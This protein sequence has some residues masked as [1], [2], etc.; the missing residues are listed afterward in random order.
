VAD[1]PIKYI[2][3][4]HY[5]VFEEKDYEAWSAAGTNR[6]ASRDLNCIQQLR[7]HLGGLKELLTTPGHEGNLILFYLPGFRWTLDKLAERDESPESAD[8]L[9]M[10]AEVATVI[11]S[12]LREAGLTNHVRFMTAQD[13][14]PILEKAHASLKDNFTRFFIGD[15]HGIRYDGPKIVEAI[16]RLR[17]LGNGIP[18][19]RLDH[20]VLFRF[21]FRKKEKVIGDLGLFK[22]VSCATLAYRLR[23]E[24]PT[25]STFLFSVS[26]NVREITEP[27]DGLGKFERWSRA[28][29][30]RVYP[31]LIATPSAVDS[32]IDLDQCVD[33]GLLKR[34]YGID[35]SAVTG[36]SV[37]VKGLAEVGAHPFYA[38]VSGA[39]LCLSDGAIVDLPPFS[40]FRVNVMWID[41][42]LK[43]SLH[44]ALK[45][46]TSGETLDL[47]I[48]RLSN[49]RLD[50]VTVIKARPLVKRLPVY[51]F[52]S[53]LPTLLWGTIMDSWITP[54]SDSILKLRHSKLDLSKMKE[55]E[56]A[57]ERDGGGVLPKAVAK[58][59]GA[60]VFTHADS[61]TL[62]RSL[63]DC[64][65]RRV[66]KVRQMWA[67]LRDGD[68]RTFASYWAGDKNDVVST[69]SAHFTETKSHLWEGIAPNRPLDLPIK[70]IDD[71]SSSVASNILGLVNNA[72]TYVH[73]TTKWPQ[74]VQIFRS[75]PQGQFKGDLTWKPAITARPASMA[76]PVSTEKSARMAATGTK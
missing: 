18:V 36:R 40:N 7:H 55:W 30:T 48:P 13:L 69:F 61:F 73:W 25:V 43:Y 31:A 59:L 29:A 16:I 68:K 44:R 57:K 33:E 67:L 58:A 50:D 76:K 63:I 21:D 27:T 5:G 47:K 6:K 60:G 71:V 38:V 24:D 20:D 41:D 75:I 1:T 8:H 28:F 74:F 65:L 32:D 51:V 42:H 12:E 23:V 64:A 2:L 37:E 14:K 53:Y 19:F 22:A 17:L 35:E 56:D 34:F 49:A 26:Y 45:H 70:T 66:E 3:Y 46:F 9:V 39:L 15:Q 72:V 52:D 62:E 10:A 54:D 11:E 4:S